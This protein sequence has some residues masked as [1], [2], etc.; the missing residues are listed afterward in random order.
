MNTNFCHQNILL[1]QQYRPELLPLSGA[2][3]NRSGEITIPDDWGLSAQPLT[4][5]LETTAGLDRLE[6]GFASLHQS[7]PKEEESL[8]FVVGLGLG[9]EAQ[10]LLEKFPL[11]RLIVLEPNESLFQ[12]VLQSRDL[13]FI[14]SNTR[15]ALHVGSG[16]NTQQILA[17]ED[18][19]MRALPLYLV[20]NKRLL[21]LLPDSYGPLSRKLI[22]EL[23]HFQGRLSTIEQ[24]GPLLFANTLKNLQ[25]LSESANM[26]A[27]KNFARGRPAVCVASGPSLTKNIAQLKGKERSLFIIAVDSAVQTLLDHGIQP[28]LIATIDPIPASRIKLKPVIEGNLP[29]PLAWTPESYPAT[30]AGVHGQEKFVVPGVNDLFRIYFSPLTG[31]NSVFPHMLSVTHTATHVAINAGC[32]PLIYIGLDLAVYGDK[33]HADGCPI[34]WTNLPEEPRFPVTAWDG[35]VVETI[36][37]LQ[38]QMLSLESIIR[39][40]RDI[41]FIDATEGGA[42]ISGSKTMPLRDAIATY[43]S[44]RLDMHFLLNTAFNQAEKPGIPAISEVLQ[45]LQSEIKTSQQLAKTGTRLGLEAINL[46]KLA[47]IPAKQAHS[48]KEFQKVLVSS[49]ESF[50]RLLAMDDLTNALYPL[51]AREH[52][53]FIHRREKFRKTAA[54]K[55]PEQ[56]IFEELDLNLSYFKSW[57][58]TAEEALTIIEPV[59]GELSGRR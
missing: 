47:K 42:L 48:L 17:Q 53:R 51:R 3:Q 56:R 4:R 41:E 6:N 18:D 14:L 37:V 44:D 32:N 1:L 27:L 57:L 25:K 28:H 5:L 52:H 38:N 29:L 46:W 26:A 30:V 58:A 20:I 39:Q 24:Q 59:V 34:K 12:E 54:A 49:G 15:L 7:L 40:H 10:L 36:T 16:I 43:A 2:Q 35:G 33:D 13:R 9:D 19:A 45:K 22:A 31:H 55:T 50:D 11:L 21:E 23:H 8:L